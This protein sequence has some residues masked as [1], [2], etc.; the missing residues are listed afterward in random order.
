[1]SS[2]G[3]HSLPQHEGGQ[4]AIRA[5]RRIFLKDLQ[6]QVDECW[7]S[8]TPSNGNPIFCPQGRGSVPWVALGVAVGHLLPGLLPVCVGD[9][10]HS[11]LT[12]CVHCNKRGRN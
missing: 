5:E 9:I 8:L 4:K 10:N 11:G 1:M 12:V 6:P 2:K 7:D 3:P